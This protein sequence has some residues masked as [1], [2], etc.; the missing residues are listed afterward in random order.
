M[1]TPSP[2]PR[3][4]SPTPAELV[5]LPR[6]LILAKRAQRG[7]SVAVGRPQPRVRLRRTLPPLRIR[8]PLLY[9]SCTLRARQSVIPPL[10]VL[11][12]VA[13]VVAITVLAFAARGRRLGLLPSE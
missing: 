11:L 12:P 10:A 4:P 6:G 3:P 5:T 1:L 7:Q 13:T 9:G 8:L 2:L